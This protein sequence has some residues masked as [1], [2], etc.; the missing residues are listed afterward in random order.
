M[1]PICLS[2]MQIFFSRDRRE[3][4]YSK[5][6]YKQSFFD[7]RD[8]QNRR[9]DLY[10]D[11]NKQYQS[12]L[13]NQKN[14]IKKA[15]STSDIVY[16]LFPIPFSILKKIMATKNTSTTIKTQ[17]RN[18][19]KIYFLLIS[20]T[21]LIGTLVS[22]GILTY[23]IGK[24]M[25]ITDD[26]YIVG[27]RYYEMDYCENNLKARPTASNPEN[28]AAPTQAEKET[29]KAEKKIQLIQSR[30]ATFKTDVLSGAIWGTLF[31]ILLLTHYPRFI[32][33]TKKDE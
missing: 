5:F 22:F 26:E 6:H 10:R 12:I 8:H 13:Q 31:L 23:T 17:V 2:D 9:Y 27:D 15:E 14:E 1:D 32:T 3:G 33:L 28:M 24:Q 18:P 16:F 7:R 11:T 30:K 21:G 19:L 25:I 4:R 20:L 29:C